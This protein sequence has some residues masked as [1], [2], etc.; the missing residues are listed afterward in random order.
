MPGVGSSHWQ[1]EPSWKGSALNV[2]GCLENPV[3]HLLLQEELSSFEN[4]VLTS[5]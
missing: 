5:H 3:V 2:I 1:L 4:P